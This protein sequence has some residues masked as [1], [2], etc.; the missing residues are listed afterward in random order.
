MGRGRKH[1]TGGRGQKRKKHGG[2]DKLS[3]KQ[4]KHLK[5]Y[6]EL[7]PMDTRSDG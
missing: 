1:Q 6:G 7:H 4:M 3:K 5:Q 2:V